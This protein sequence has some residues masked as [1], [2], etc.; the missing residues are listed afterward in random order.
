MKR[1][2]PTLVT[3][4]IAHVIGSYCSG[5]LPV[6]LERILHPNFHGPVLSAWSSFFAA[7]ALPA[8]TPL[9]LIGETV[10]AFPHYY[11]YLPEY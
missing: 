7:L 10:A 2:H 3:L 9:F 4:L 8:I 6:I 5:L 11:H 1:F